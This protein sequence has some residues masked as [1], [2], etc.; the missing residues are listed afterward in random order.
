M[1]IIFENNTFKYEVESV[2]KL[3]FPCVLFQHEYDTPWKERDDV[4]VASLSRGAEDTVLTGLV[5]LQGK[6]CTASQTVLNEDF[7][8]EE[9]CERLLCVAVYHAL[10]QATGIHVT[11]GVMTGIRPVKQ[12]NYWIEKG[13]SMEEVERI[14]AEDYLVTPQKIDL[15]KKTRKNQVEIIDASKPNSYSLYVSIP[16]CPSRCSYCSFVSSSIAA[17]KAKALVGEYVEKLCEE[18][19][20]M[21]KQVEGL[22]LQL[23]TAYIGG[24]TPTTLSADQLTQLT[25]CMRESFPLDQAKEFTIEAGRADT[26]TRDKLEAIKQA[27]ATRISINPQTFNDQVLKN[28]GRK[29]TAQQVVDCY[30]MAQEMGFE[31]INM[32]FIAGLPGDT[33]ESFCKT[34]DEAVMLNPTN[35]T[36]HTLTIKRSSDLFHAG[37]LDESLP[38]MEISKMVEYAY[39]ALT[40]AGYEPYYLYRQKNTLQNLENV[41]YCKPGY[42]GLYNIYIMEEIHTIL[43]AGASA[44]SKLIRKK[45]QKVQRIFNYKYPFEYN[46]DFADILERKNAIREFYTVLKPESS[47]SLEK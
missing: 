6:E 43:A 21:G 26:I 4:I 42:E 12:M 39:Q 9:E 24:G 1:T 5:R 23:E 40:Q 19:R 27:G 46:R 31:D 25:Q 3:F 35:I 36:V 8:Y 28:I 37:E 22:G 20:Y 11:W 38:Q 18:I 47:I 29:H 2:C 34:I 44:V 16:F 32:D 15:C 45:S 17:P 10:E 41:G 7:R 13:K 14:F 33:Y 30:H